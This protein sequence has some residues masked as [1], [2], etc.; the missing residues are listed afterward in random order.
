MH[1]SA[2]QITRERLCSHNRSI[3]GNVL[4]FALYTGVVRY[5]IEIG[6]YEKLA[7]MSQ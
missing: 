4:T 2:M 5:E 3:N 1:W 6:I 7:K